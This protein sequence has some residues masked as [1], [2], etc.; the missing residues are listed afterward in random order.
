MR[1]TR[2]I[3]IAALAAGSLPLMAQAKWEVTRTMHVGGEGAWDYVT[4]DSPRHQLFVTRATHTQVIDSTNGKL[5][6]DIS[7][8]IRSHGVALVPGYNR[9][10]ITDGGGKGAIVIFDLKSYQTLGKVDALP[11][12]D[13]IIYDQSTNLVL[14]VSGDEG[15]LITLKP[16]INPNGG[17]IDTVELGGK[18]EFLAADGAGKAYI[19]LVDKDVVVAVDLKAAKVIA[20]WSVAPGG[21]PVGMALDQK[22]HRLYIGCRDPQKLIV[23]NTEDGK[24]VADLPIGMGVDAAKVDGGTAF[25]SCSDGTLTVVSQKDGKYEVEQVVKTQQGS[26]TMGVDPTNHSVFLPAA[27]FEPPAPGARPTM[28]ADSF[29]IL[30]VSKR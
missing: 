15:K 3:L 19:A 22:N 5:L 11:D 12:T 16:D 14:A 1:I 28:K 30:V 26:R 8:Q 18:P 21:K 6:G 4:V 7:G 27:E 13:G 29:S 17:K 25:A 10:F 20:R 9:G 23:M 2:M 24:V